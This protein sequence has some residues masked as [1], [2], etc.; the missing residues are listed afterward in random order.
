MANKKR[1]QEFVDSLYNTYKG[2]LDFFAY[3]V[4]KNPD[5]GFHYKIENKEYSFFL[6]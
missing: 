1:E 2:S 4:K 5:V 6:E 3:R